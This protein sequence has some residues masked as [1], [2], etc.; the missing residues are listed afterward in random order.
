MWCGGR[1]VQPKQ[2]LTAWQQPPSPSTITAASAPASTGRVGQKKK[3]KAASLAD[4]MLREGGKELKGPVTLRGIVV[5]HDQD[6]E[7]EE[8]P[9]LM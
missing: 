9:P 1:Q 3:K 7:G 2:M 5:S 6:R 4:Q 8:P